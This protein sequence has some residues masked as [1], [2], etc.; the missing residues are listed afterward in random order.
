MEQAAQLGKLEAV[1]PER[2]EKITTSFSDSV[3]DDGH[4]DEDDASIDLIM[5]SRA[6]PVDVTSEAV[7]AQARLTTMRIEHSSS[8]S[9]LPSAFSSPHHSSP[10]TPG[11]N[12]PLD[13]QS[14]IA[15]QVSHLIAPRKC[16]RCK[17]KA[18]L[19]LPA[20]VSFRSHRPRGKESGTRRVRTKGQPVRTGHS[21]P[22]QPGDMQGSLLE[23]EGCP[24]DDEGGVE[25][26]SDGEGDRYTGVGGELS[27]D[28]PT[29]YAAPPTIALLRRSKRYPPQH[30]PIHLETVI[31]PP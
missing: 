13:R 16:S 5:T 12:T 21:F 4:P 1:V 9:A 11:T 29:G 15:S 23:I 18:S 27:P 17:S 2:H 22:R 20:S 30:P 26:G 31:R 24:A 10:M 14:S 25:D 8:L 28:G 7:A 19:R 6:E 3:V